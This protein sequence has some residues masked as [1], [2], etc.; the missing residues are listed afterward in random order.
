LYQAFDG[1][2]KGER[3]EGAWRSATTGNP[4]YDTSRVFQVDVDEERLDELRGL[5]RR[6]CKTFVQ[7]C[8]RVIVRGEVEYLEGGDDDQPL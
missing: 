1:W 8:L 5:L 7:Q 6:A 4:V 3:V 2:T